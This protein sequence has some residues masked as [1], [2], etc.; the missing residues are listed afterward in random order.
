[1]KKLILKRISENEHAT[2]GVFIFEMIPICVSL[3]LPWRDNDRNIS[4]I[5]EGMYNCSFDGDR[6]LVHHVPHRSAV[7]IHSGNLPRDTRGCI[8]PGEEF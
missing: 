6:Y 4:C 1:M 3:E 2:F 8:L 5:P 7:Q